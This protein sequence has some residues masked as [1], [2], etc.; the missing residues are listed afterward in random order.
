MKD[1]ENRVRDFL[2]R[3]PEVARRIRQLHS[4]TLSFTMVVDI[5]DDNTTV[6][7]DMAMA[8]QTGDH[9][10]SRTYRV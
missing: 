5:L 10:A 3:Y 7:R 1:A 9:F 4:Q 2:F 6:L 8:N